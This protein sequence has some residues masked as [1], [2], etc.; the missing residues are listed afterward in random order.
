MEEK[1]TGQK[2]KRNNEEH[3]NIICLLFGYKDI[4]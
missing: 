3:R 4:T 2:E 1:K